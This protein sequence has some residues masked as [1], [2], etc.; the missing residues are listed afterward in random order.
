MLYKNNKKYFPLLIILFIIQL[1][2]TSCTT[3]PMEANASLSQPWISDIVSI[4]DGGFNNFLALDEN[5]DIIAI[6]D[7]RIIKVDKN[8]FLVSNTDFMQPQESFGPIR[9]YDGI[10]YKFVNQA[11]FSDYDPDKKLLVKIYNTSGEFLASKTIDIKGFMLDVEF[12][13]SDIIGVMVWNS[14]QYSMSCKK[15]HLENGLIDEIVINSTGSFPSR[16]TIEESGNY[17]ITNSGEAKSFTYLDSELNI[18][19]ARNYNDFFIKQV[20]FI[21][22][23]G[24]FAIGSNPGVNSGDA[25][26]LI[27]PDDGSILNKIDTDVD[28][29]KRIMDFQINDE[30]ICVSF[31]EPESTKNLQLMFFDYDLNHLSSI[32]ITGNVSSSNIIINEKESFAFLY[33]LQNDENSNEFA[34]ESHPRI[35][36]LDKTYTLPTN[37]IE[38]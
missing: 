15:F 33:G 1:S 22:D 38:Q 5:N 12:E 17:M 23:Y 8:G 9:I 31:S 7:E 36:C 3:E 18:I 34:P 14:D 10:I 25:I 35:F 37:I 16:L 11:D 4:P 27:S 26:A 20:K 21:P 24:I 29:S 28:P 2:I 32:D 19:W 30:I 13:N 6:N